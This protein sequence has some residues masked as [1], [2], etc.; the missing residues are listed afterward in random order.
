VKARDVFAVFG[1]SGNGRNRESG[2]VTRIRLLGVRRSSAPSALVALA[3]ALVALILPATAAAADPT[4]T[5]DPVATHSIVTAKVSGTVT[6]DEEANGGSE[7]FW[8]FQY[9]QQ[10]VAGECTASSTWNFGPEAFAHTLP[11]GSSAVPVE[12]TL[13][14]LHAETGYAVRLAAYSFSGPEFFS[15]EGEY[16]TFTTDSATA[17]TLALDAPGTVAYTTAEL[18]GSINPEGG[19]TDAVSGLLPISWELQ[20][21]PVSEPGNWQAAGSTSE[22]PLEGANAEA[23]TA[24]AV[25]AEATGLTP[26]TEYRYRL[27]AQ[28]AGLTAETDEV[29]WGEFTTLPVTKPTAE[30]LQVTNL[31]GTSAE[32]Q[33]L[34]KPNAPAGPLDP[35][36]E[37]AY[38]TTWSFSPGG[39]S[40]TTTATTAE[41]TVHGEAVGL[42]PNH[43]YT[44]AFTAH[45]AGG[46]KELTT[47]FTTPGIAPTISGGTTVEV[48][49]TTARL[50]IELKPGSPATTYRF[51]Y[52]TTIAYGQATPD[53]HLLENYLSA[54]PL[55]VQLSDLA[56]ETRYH[57]RLVAENAFE[58][59]EGADHAFITL[60]ASSAGAQLPDNR[61]WEQVTPPDKNG[62]DLG[63]LGIIR[64]GFIPGL[65]ERIT[66]KEILGASIQSSAEGN[67]IDLR[68]T[69]AGF[70]DAKSENT[71]TGDY[72]IDRTAE[73]WSTH[74]I[75]EPVATTPQLFSVP[76]HMLFSD[77][78][79]KSLYLRPDDQPPLTPDALPYTTGYYVRNTDDGALRY[80]YSYEF[81][82]F[83]R[84]EWSADAV[85]TPDLSHVFQRYSAREE[86]G[87]PVG[88]PPGT[89]REGSFA[90]QPFGL[91]ESYETPDG[92]YAT[93]MASILPD[94]TPVDGDAGGGKVGPKENSV[95]RTGDR[96]VFTTPA[97]DDICAIVSGGQEVLVAEGYDCDGGRDIGEGENKVD[98]APQIYIRENATTTRWI[99]DYAAGVPVDPEAGLGQHFWG[100]DEDVGHVF[101]TSQTKL[102]A[103]STASHDSGDRTATGSYGD[104][105]RYDV[106]ANGGAG[107][108]RDIT[109][110]SSRPEGAQVIGVLGNSDD[111][112]RIYFVA[113]SNH[114]D[115]EQGVAGQANL[116]LWDNHGGSPT[117]TY[118]ATLIAFDGSED[119][120]FG[121]W[122]PNSYE[123]SS[124]VTPSGELLFTSMNQLTD[125]ENAGHSE[126]YVYDPQADYLMCASCFGDEPATRDAFVPFSKIMSHLPASIHHYSLS[127]DGHWAFFNTKASLVAGD[128]NGQ[129]D[130]YRFDTES[131]KVALLS[132]GQSSKPSYFLAAGR[133]GRDAFFLTS[134]RLLPSDIDDNT[135]IY[136]ARVNGGIASQNRLP[137]TPCEGDACQPPPVVPNDPTPS[138]SSFVGPGDKQVKKHHRKAHHKK[139]HRKKAAGKQRGHKKHAR[140]GKSTRRH[141]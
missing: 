108:L 23:N 32:F 6:F 74:N 25:A 89:N 40:G 69:L 104:L 136:D 80:L 14:G 18:S 64:S 138:S 90:G 19:N 71:Y 127:S 60:A 73:G 134:E 62:A 9:C 28:Y 57:W 139:G 55:S 105:Y 102:T 47:T 129:L 59:V 81:R 42:K 11:A 31:T 1:C 107:E 61:A 86:T 119:N 118:V 2:A 124:E 13:T 132:S 140:H 116:Y 24:V 5:V 51:E 126:V 93:R 101:F 37:A 12:E 91:Y 56:P 29:D 128:N 67:R 20:Y 98:A 68:S 123:R 50:K 48:G 94:G 3:A 66:G 70:A 78:L 35:A 141:G 109:V 95:S 87:L 30:D 22:S 82:S 114:L 44:V 97:V 92:S 76:L 41:E 121:N 15:P 122:L 7:G 49:P 43:E 4:L 65:S 54:T 45:N 72:I 112:E 115:G 106:E 21:A 38:E 137:A 17:P 26:G 113:R 100:A 39:S 83:D 75:D 34:V 53:G 110:D 63:Q 130:A 131:G 133:D 99:S 52:G 79:S 10:A 111:G 88:V 58:T 84:S 135:D 103:D 36:A 8:F 16:R 117:T 27:V 96:V 33:A 125:F 77:S 120:D 85:A 46:T